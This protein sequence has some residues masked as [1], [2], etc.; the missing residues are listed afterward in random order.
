[1]VNSS[2]EEILQVIMSTVRVRKLQFV[3]DSWFFIPQQDE[4]KL[5]NS[6]RDLHTNTFVL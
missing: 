6:A 2:V 5:R 3:V 4:K 1:M